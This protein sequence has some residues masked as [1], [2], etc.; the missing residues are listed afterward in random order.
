MP[1]K[2]VRRAEAARRLVRHPAVRSVPLT[3]LVVPAAKGFTI[4]AGAALLVGALAWAVALNLL[5]PLGRRDR[6]A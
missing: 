6:P 5:A 2:I 1:T 3:A 4:G